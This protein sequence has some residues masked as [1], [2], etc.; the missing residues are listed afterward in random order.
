M[1]VLHLR[2][3]HLS[4]LR[5]IEMVDFQDRIIH[6]GEAGNGM[7]IGILLIIGAVGWRE[8]VNVNT[9]DVSICVTGRTILEGLMVGGKG[10]GVG[11][12]GDDIH[13]GGKNLARTCLTLYASGQWAS[14]R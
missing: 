12:M 11:P 7:R 13:D 4:D 2:L 9:T 6:P 8:N 3:R 5:I 1:P 14:V 10:G